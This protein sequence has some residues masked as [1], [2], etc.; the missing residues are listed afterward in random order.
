MEEDVDALQKTL[1]EVRDRV[2]RKR[3][4]SPP[5]APNAGAEQPAP[6]QHPP[7]VP[8]ASGTQQAATG[9]VSGITQQSDDQERKDDERL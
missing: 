3:E 5:P 2:K 6:P 8:G 4:S 9:P 1:D 7:G